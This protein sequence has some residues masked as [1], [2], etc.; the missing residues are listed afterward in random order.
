MTPCMQP[1]CSRPQVLTGEI[2]R[3]QALLAQR[4]EAV[5]QWQREAELASQLAEVRGGAG[6]R[7]AVLACAGAGVSIALRKSVQ[8]SKKGSKK[9]S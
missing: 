9:G 1:P 8:G 5:Q 7:Q 3:L 2:E 6:R 4:E